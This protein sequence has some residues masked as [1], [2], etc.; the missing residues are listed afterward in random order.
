MNQDRSRMMVVDDGRLRGIIALR[1]LM[2]FFS[3]KI[4]LDENAPG[5]QASSAGAG[6]RSASAGQQERQRQQ[7]N[8]SGS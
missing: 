4:E 6:Q 1:D 2:R 7:A 8:P 3:L 5:Q